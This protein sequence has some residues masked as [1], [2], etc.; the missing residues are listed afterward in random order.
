MEEKEHLRIKT[1]NNL[2]EV[3][4][5]KFNYGAPPSSGDDKEKTPYYGK[6]AEQFKFYLNKYRT[7]VERKKE[8]QEIDVASNIDYIL[9]NFQSHFV[10][11][12]FYQYW[13]S[14]FGLEAVRFTKFN[15][16]V[17]FAIIDEEKF[18]HFIENVEAFINFG[19]KN[20][21]DENFDNKIK[22]IKAFKLFTT[23]DIL[24]FREQDLGEV[25]NLNLINLPLEAKKEKEIREA[26]FTFL[27]SEEISYEFYEETNKIE[28]QNINFDQILKLSNNFDLISSIT[29]SLSSVV[30]PSEFNTV[31]REYGFNISNSEDEDLPI[32][33]IIDTG[34]S[35]ETP[36][37]S[38]TIKDDRFN[39][40]AEDPLVDSCGL[41]GH[42]TAVAAL[43][44]LGV[45]LY[46]SDFTGNIETDAKLLSIKILADSSSYL[47]EKKIIE[48]LYRVKDEYPEIKIFVL[49]TCFD[50]PKRTNEPYTSY[51]FDLDKFAYK[52]DSLIF[53]CTGNNDKAWI[54]NHDYDPNYFLSPH[55]NL[56]TPADSLNNITIGSAADN[57][58]KDV[59]LGISSGREFP[60]LYSRKCHI[61]LKQFYPKNKTNKHLFKPDV[62][63]SGGDYEVSAGGIGSH[64]NAS[65]KVLSANPA[66][67]F[68]KQIGTSFSTPLVANLAAKICRKYPKLNVQSI[69]ALII[70]G[71]SINAIRFR[72]PVSK[73]INKIAGSG[74]TNIQNSLNSNDNRIT[75]IMEDSIR[76]SEMKIF[77]IKF[78][79]YLTTED[80]GKKNGIL[81]LSATICYKFQPIPNNHLSYC[82]LNIGFSFFKNHTREEIIAKNDTVDSKLKS[83]ISWTQSGRYKSKPIP[84]SNSQKLEFPIN[85]KELQSEKSLFKL[86]VHCTLSNQLI[87]SELDG[88]PQ[89]HDYSLVLTIEES[90]KNNTNKL[91]SAFAEINNLE[92]LI[93]T[94]TEG[95]I[96]IEA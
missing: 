62:V 49:T 40:T 94:D 24:K 33:G 90:L 11:D 43:A 16:E 96:D 63:E 88:Y 85:L 14:T 25:V 50:L 17:L 65:L 41:E 21:K 12:Q 58:N 27:D 60:T 81:K 79:E 53:I 46:E 26:I 87:A 28:L 77:D 31:K 82:P 52:T 70:N 69:K 32:I 36:L 1:S 72:N 71:S 57:I 13:Y 93:T 9:I 29:S 84:F 4:E 92:S 61:D 37:T 45:N 20:T 78:P 47:S 76:N 55:T 83:G 89:S 38:I 42:G 74:F 68:Y 54:E 35:Q 19:L 95:E 7:D 18:K 91:Y 30:K 8:R 3:G 67:G 23:I 51:T 64:I 15:I 56:C 44:S 10:I 48:L 22:Y 73:I 6:M 66:E 75:A 86:A 5:I 59:F 34:I 2:S 39:L 80:L